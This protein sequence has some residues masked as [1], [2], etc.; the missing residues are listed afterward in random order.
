MG[1][2]YVLI[3]ASPADDMQELE[4]ATAIEDLSKDSF[5]EFV[6][7]YFAGAGQSVD[8][9]ML[10]KQLQER[11]GMDLE[12]KQASGEMP[13]EALDRL[14]ASTSVEIFPVLLPTKETSFEAVSVYCDDKGV[15][16]GLAENAR[17]SGLVQACGYPSQTFRGDC[18]V[19]RVFDDTEEEW[20]R[21]D[22]GLA[23]CS[24]DAAWVALAR[25]QRSGRSSGDLKALASQIGARNPA[26]VAPAMEDAP[27]GETAAYR[28]RQADDE[29][30]VTFKKE[31]L[32][33]GEKGLV[34]VAFARQRLRVEV[35]G[36]VLLD[37]E[38]GGRT[39]PDESTWT[40]SDGVLQV[41]L[42]KAD[43]GSWPQLV[44]A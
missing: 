31:G 11:T 5:R 29:V 37:T 3:P 18:F 20:R 26:H 21:M 19:G 2:Q 35:K 41:S 16:K 30:E 42:A 32:Q 7:K 13:A 9:S 14:L 33:K 44:K 43:A 36:E 23:D 22:F 39:H 10:L 28:W 25:H 15:A 8:R 34:R 27:A 1:F 17:V 24:T 6:E 4:Y 12:G 38:L 40:L